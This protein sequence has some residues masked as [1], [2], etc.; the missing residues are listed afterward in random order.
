M[1][2]FSPP[3]S[4][5][6]PILKCDN[7]IL[8]FSPQTVLHTERENIFFWLFAHLTNTWEN[9][10]KIHIRYFDSGFVR[11]LNSLGGTAAISD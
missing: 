8:I 11:L 3:N 9:I 2:A 7:D 10:K 5:A 4:H 6:F 1:S